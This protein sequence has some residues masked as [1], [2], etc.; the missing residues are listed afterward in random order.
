MASRHKR[1]LV[2]RIGHLGDTIIALPAFW[3]IRN[4]FPDAHIA[5][6]TNSDPLNPNYVSASSVLPTQGLF[7]ETISYPA[8]TGGI[9][10]YFEMIKLAGK[11]RKFAPDHVFY[12]MPRIRTLKQIRR[13]ELFFGLA[14]VKDL[15]GA[16]HLRE[17]RLPARADYPAVEIN[18]EADHLLR[19]LGFDEPILDNGVDDLLRLNEGEIAVG[20][21]LIEQSVSSGADPDRII[22]VAPGSKWGSKVWAEENYR[23]VVQRLIEEFDIFP[24]VFGGPEDA[25]KGERLLRNCGRGICAAGKLNVRE[26]AAAMKFCKL[27]LGN[28]TGTMHLAAAVGTKCVA[29]FAAVDY[30]GR[31]YPF[32][33][34]HKIFREQV[35]C[36]GCQTP[37]CFNDH[38]CLE[39]IKTGAVLDGCREI[40]A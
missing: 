20:R 33:S 7:D 37:L 26:S 10:Y 23:E 29:I 30:P 22:A 18:S 38:L 34:G 12:L 9:G 31:W 11:V 40:L 35:P 16:D 5:L 21:D 36:E 25:E 17:N 6:L 39:K 19:S 27:Y 2:F 13:D 4:R 24:I 32:G 3:E 1:I 14:G 28:D 15:I 8:T